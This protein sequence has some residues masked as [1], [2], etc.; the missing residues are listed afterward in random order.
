MQGNYSYVKKSLEI[1]RKYSF[2]VLSR[3]DVI[4]TPK[5][6]DESGD[7]EPKATENASEKSSTETPKSDDTDNGESEY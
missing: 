3:R 5:D 2:V 6:D 7:D 1:L 4:V